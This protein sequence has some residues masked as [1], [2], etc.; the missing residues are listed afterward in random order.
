MKR[1]DYL[2]R[3]EPAWAW[4]VMALLGAAFVLLFVLGLKGDIT[5]RTVV[6]LSACWL[7][8]LAGNVLLA[9]MAAYRRLIM[10]MNRRDNIRC[11]TCGYDLRKNTSGVCPECGNR[12]DQTP[13]S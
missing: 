8:A 1:K 5:P 9:R 11:I 3:Y 2:S 12:T 10:S 13:V 6:W 4:R 7:L